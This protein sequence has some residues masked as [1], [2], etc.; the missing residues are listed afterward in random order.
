[1]WRISAAGPIDE[2]QVSMGL[3]LC[4]GPGAEIAIGSGDRGGLLLMRRYPRTP[5]PRPAFGL[6][7][8]PPGGRGQSWRYPPRS[9]VRGAWGI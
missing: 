7:P 2:D 1:M 5:P 8:R 4:S 9:T 6:L 3:S